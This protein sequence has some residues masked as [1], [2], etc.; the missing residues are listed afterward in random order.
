MKNT[1]CLLLLLLVHGATPLL[2]QQQEVRYSAAD[3][4]ADL[5]SLYQGLEQAHFNLYAF[6][7]K[8]S[9]QRAFRQFNKAIGS[10]SLSLLE[11]HKLFQRFTALG[12]VG[13]SEL[14]FPAQAYIAYAMEGGR[15]IPLELAF[16]GEKVYIRKTLP[17]MPH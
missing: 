6:T 10:D 17:A 5:A 12:R 3:V 4:K 2:A 8:R 13:H 14:D 15:L 11:T 16:E 9:Y 7:P 1:L